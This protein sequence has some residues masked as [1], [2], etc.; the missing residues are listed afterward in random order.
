MASQKAKVFQEIPLECRRYWRLLKRYFGWLLEEYNFTLLYVKNGRMSSCGFVLQADDCRVHISIDR[1]TFGGIRIAM[2]P[3]S[4]ISEVSI[5]GLRW[6]YVG[7][8]VDYLRGWYPKWSQIEEASR[9][10]S[11][12]SLNEAMKKEAREIRPFWPQIM[13]LFREDMFEQ[14][15]ASLEEFLEREMQDLHKQSM[16]AARRR[17]AEWLPKWKEKRLYNDKTNYED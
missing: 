12:L 16:K 14:R 8:I 17:E 6:Y 5:R 10:D 13:D 4:R 9:Q 1:G 11:K 2:V 3:S 15:K 7:E